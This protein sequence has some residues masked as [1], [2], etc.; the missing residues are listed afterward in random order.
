MFP[1]LWTILN[2]IFFS[3][4]PVTWLLSADQFYRNGDFPKE[5]E[6]LLA[7]QQFWSKNFTHLDENRSFH[8]GIQVQISINEAKSSLCASSRL[9][10]DNDLIPH[11]Q[12][13]VFFIEFSV[14]FSS[15]KLSYLTQFSFLLPVFGSS[16]FKIKKKRYLVS[17]MMYKFGAQPLIMYQLYV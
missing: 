7:R 5:E 1:S 16:N 8:P 9:R 12:L 11:L 14:G 13:F 3:Y 17:S 4:K 2:R 6:Q 10:E 15:N